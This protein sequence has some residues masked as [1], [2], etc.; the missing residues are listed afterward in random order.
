MT[1]ASPHIAMKS[2]LTKGA[3]RRGRS[4]ALVINACFFAYLGYWLYRNVNYENLLNEFQQIPLRPIFVAMAMNLCV[5]SFFGLRLAAILR[6][7]ALPC[8]LIATIGFT[9]NALIP[10]RIGEGV[11]I[12]FGST[13]FACPVG[14][15]SAAIVMEKLYDLSALVAL[16]TLVAFS[17]RSS[18]VDIGRP[19]IVALALLLMACGG[20]FVWARRRGAIPHPSEWRLLA[21]GRLRTF[22]EQAESSLLNQNAPRAALFTA[23]IWTTNVC[24]VLLLFSSILPSTPFGL[25]DAMTLIVIASL[26]IAMP[27]SPAGLGIFEA[28]IVSYLTTM[29]DVQKEKAI[30]AALA[31]HLSITAPHTIIVILFLGSVFLRQLKARWAS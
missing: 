2:R 27:A 12:Y 26:A 10:F 9:F 21:W 25:L 8:F 17:S 30:S 31:Y 23:L 5:L 16:A 4:V 13:Y 14:G 22:A 7:D 18:I 29:Y 3:L 24:L 6:A 20:L 11:K 28:G 19:T 15:L 1:P